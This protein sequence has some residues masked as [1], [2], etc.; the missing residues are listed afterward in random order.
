[1]ALSSQV[2]VD[3]SKFQQ[4]VFELRTD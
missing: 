1:V 4:R 2:T 3:I